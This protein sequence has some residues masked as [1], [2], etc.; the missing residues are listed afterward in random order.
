M[1]I[2]YSAPDIGLNDCN[3]GSAHVSGVINAMHKA[4]HN[5]NLICNSGEIDNIIKI[6]KFKSGL[7][8]VLNYFF[9]PFFINRFTMHWFSLLM[10]SPEKVSVSQSSFSPSL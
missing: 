2:I 6:K 3:G 7:F 10:S 8:R 9:S 5:V 1:K 4:G